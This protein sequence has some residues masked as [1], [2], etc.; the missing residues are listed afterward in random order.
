M[1]D[2]SPFRSAIER[3]E[4]HEIIARLKKGLFS[5]EAKPIAE[6]VLRARGI[7]PSNPV[8][9]ADQRLSTIT[10]TPGKPK[11]LPFLFAAIAATMA[12]RHIGAAIAGAIGAGLA[13]VV[14]WW[15]AWWVGA[16]VA[17]QLRK[18]QSPPMRGL[19]SLVAVFA[20]LFAMGVI[21]IAVQS[22]TGRLRT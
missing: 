20:W 13:A 21:G 3:M 7:D 22:G 11:L 17:L 12:G 4:E 19:V 2:D 18:I 15:P 14:L 10:R 5:E 9:P 16:T 8:V 1:P 6:A